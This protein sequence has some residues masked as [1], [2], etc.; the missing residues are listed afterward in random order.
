MHSTVVCDNMHLEVC[1][2]FLLF[3]FRYNILLDYIELYHKCVKLKMS[4]PLTDILA[5]Q[6][7]QYYSVIEP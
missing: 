1:M 6:H 2:I 7:V 5:L 3:I 4:S